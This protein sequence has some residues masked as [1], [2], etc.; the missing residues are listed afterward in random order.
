MFDN[1]KVVI[2]GISETL[3]NMLVRSFLE[4]GAFVIGADK[5]EPDFKS[6]KF[7]FIRFNSEDVQETEALCKEINDCFSGHLDILINALSLHIDVD[8]LEVNAQI[9]SSCF[10]AQLFNVIDINRKL[11]PLLRESETGN[12]SVVNIGSSSSRMNSVDVGLECLYSLASIK[13]SRIQAGSYSGVRCNS[14]SPSR[15]ENTEDYQSIVDTVLF[16]CSEDGGFIT[17]TDILIDQGK[18]AKNSA[19][20]ES[21]ND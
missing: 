15:M 11:Y 8:L 21:K 4:C 20:L 7:R 18:S 6:D 5:S 17:G 3:G 2:I 12:P 16:L 1:Y 19:R 9:F 10:S 13:L 14:I